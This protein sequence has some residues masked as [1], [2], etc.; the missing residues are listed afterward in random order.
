MKCRVRDA[1]DSF[2]EDFLLRLVQSYYT[3]GTPALFST[4]REDFLRYKRE[5]VPEFSCGVNTFRIILKKLGLVY[6]RI[7]KRAVLLQRPDI[8]AWRGR[9]LKAL[10]KLREEGW[11]IVFTDETW[12]DPFERAG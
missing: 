1:L 3:K 6:G 7:D 9:Y 2:D 10:V 12:I 11:D 8:I 5:T 4:I